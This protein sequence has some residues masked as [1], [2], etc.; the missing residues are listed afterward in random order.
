MSSRTLRWLSVALVAGIGL[1]HLALA[2]GE[3]AEAP[4]LGLLFAA[5]FVGA[6][7]AAV[8]I[9]RGQVW[10]WALG[11]L[12]AAGSIIGYILSRTVGLPG[13]EIEAWLDPF[14]LLSLL[15]EAAFIA[16]FFTIKPRAWQ[17]ASSG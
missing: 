15:V 10:G 11:I 3:Y 6:I 1:I 5:N 12:I 16:L 9:Y 13:M 8:G 7:I 4:Y 14:G 2:P 17:T